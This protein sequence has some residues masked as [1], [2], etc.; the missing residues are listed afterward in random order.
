MRGDSAMA[1]RR[2]GQV[3]GFG[4]SGIRPVSA[5]AQRANDGV[6]VSEVVRRA[7]RE[8]LHTA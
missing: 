8:H 3:G 7:L 1:V 2:R 6:T 4:A 5:A